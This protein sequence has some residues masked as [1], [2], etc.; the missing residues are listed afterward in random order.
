MFQVGR[1]ATKVSIQRLIEPTWSSGWTRSNHVAGTDIRRPSEGGAART[2]AARNESRRDQIPVPDAVTGA[3]NGQRVALFAL[4]QRCLRF[5]PRD[6]IPDRAAQELRRDVALDHVVLGSL[7]DHG[8]SRFLVLHVG[9]DDDWHVRRRSFDPA[10]VLEARAIWQIQIEQDDVVAAFGKPMQ[11]GE[12]TLNVI[13]GRRRTRK[14]RDFVT[15]Q[16]CFETVV[17]DQQNAEG[18]LFRVRAATV[19]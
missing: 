3:R 1:V 17:F 13:D 6:G 15:N 14:A 8:D 7:G 12:Q 9:Q 4:S 5:L 2:S 19:R 10:Q 11:G 16:P 18:F